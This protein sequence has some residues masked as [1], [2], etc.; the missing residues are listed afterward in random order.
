MKKGLYKFFKLNII[1]GNTNIGIFEL[2]LHISNGL[3]F[4]NASNYC[5][6][7]RSLL[8]TDGESY[9]SVEDTPSWVGKS[10]G[11]V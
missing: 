3:L 10:P 7:I 6:L 9:S 8:E 4:K 2:W 11:T 5:A 1:V